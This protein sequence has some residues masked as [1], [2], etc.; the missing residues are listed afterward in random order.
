VAGHAPAPAAPDPCKTYATACATGLPVC[1]I[2][3]NQPEGT[4]CGGTDVCIAGICGPASNRLLVTTPPASLHALPNQTLSVALRIVDQT[5]TPVATATDVTLTA[6]AGA[7]PTDAAVVPSATATTA[8]DGTVTFTPRLGRSVGPQHFT[9]TAA[10]VLDLDLVLTADAPAD[11]TLLPLADVAHAYAWS[12][13]AGP[14]SNLPLTSTHGIGVASDGTVYFTELYGCVVKRIKPDG[15]LDVVA[16]NGTCGFNGEQGPASGM[17]LYYPLAV[18]LDDASGRLYLADS[19]NARVR[20]IDLLD[21]R[22]PWLHTIAGDGTSGAPPYGDGGPATS[23]QLYYPTHVALG[24]ETP[25]AIYIADGYHNAIRRVD[26]VTNAISTL[27]APVAACSGAGLGLY[28]LSSYNG[29]GSMAFD[30]KGQLFLSGWFCGTDTGGYSIAGVARRAP[31]GTLALVV[32]AQTGVVANG[33]PARSVSFSEPPAIALDKAA[34]PSPPGAL[35]S[36][37]F[38]AAPGG[39]YLARV[40]GASGRFDVVAGTCAAGSCTAG[41]SGDF[42]PATAAALS[43]PWAIAFRPGTRDLYVAEGNTYGVALVAGAGSAAASAASLTSLTAPVS[44]FPVQSTGDAPVVPLQVKLL[45]GGGAPLGGFGVSFGLDPAGLAGGWLGASSASTASDGVAGVVARPGLALGRHGVVASFRDLH[46][47]HVAGSPA[48]IDV[49]AVAPPAG[50]VFSVANQAHATS[51]AGVPGPAAV[52]GFYQPF[53]LALA[54]DGSVYFSEGYYWKVFRMRPSG[55]VELFAGNGTGTVADGAPATASGF[56]YPGGM[57]LDEARG[58]LYVADQYNGRVRRIDL[59]PP[60]IVTTLAGGGASNAD[61]PAAATTLTYPSRL[62][63]AGGKLYVSDRTYTADRLRRIDLSAVPP[64][65]ETF[66]DVRATGALPG[67]PGVVPNC[68]DPSLATSTAFLGCG[69]DPG[70][71][72]APGPGG[73]L[74][75]SGTFCGAGT[76]NPPA[77]G[78]VYGIARVEADGTLV[79]VAGV[80]NYPV[81]PDAT[82]ASLLSFDVPVSLATDAAGNL[83]VAKR[84]SGAAEQKVGWFAADAGGLV[85]PTSLFHLVGLPSTGGEYVDQSLAGF[86]A[87]SDVAVGAHAWVADGGAGEHSVRVVW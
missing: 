24:P 55:L 43:S 36:N 23:A 58:A 80:A 38:L 85:G 5:G 77:V 51:L 82:Q 30:E 28:S 17:N 4:G 79:Y 53:G 83:W 46:G 52:A 60:N 42:G 16:G 31:D 3:G 87:P 6:P 47:D 81:L 1:G 50:T 19:Y 48:V 14:A 54:A 65:I 13:A 9:A 63:L 34:L 11:G 18:T 39:N 45:D 33:I 32:G 76:H 71:S 2:S 70:C 57:A 56:Y 41:R 27:V 26:G 7:A 69:S 12:I 74:Y 62:A 25:P 59:A 35:R 49:N 21:A 61:G 20:M 15:S 67:P 73:R 64:A 68:S 78:T 37:L 66:L 8:A 86:T 72:V 40:D 84:G 22:G 29:S 75:V 44:R 10:G